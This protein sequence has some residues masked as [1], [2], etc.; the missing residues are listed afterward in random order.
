MNRRVDIDLFDFPT[1]DEVLPLFKE[2]PLY[3]YNFREEV[4][5]REDLSPIEQ[6]FDYQPML[7]S[8]VNLLN[9]KAFQVNLSYAYIK[10]YFKR[11]IP[12]KLDTLND[13]TNEQWTNKVHFEN[14]TDVFFQKAFT[15]LDLLGHLL[16]NYFDL[17][18]DPKRNG[19]DITFN[20]VLYMLPQKDKKLFH[21]LL[22]IKKSEEFK[23]ASSIRNDIIHSNPPYRAHIRNRSV[24]GVVFTKTHY[25]N[26]EELMQ[27]MNKLLLTMKHIFEVVKK[28]IE[29]QKRRLKKPAQKRSKFIHF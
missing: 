10:Y 5:Y 28:H 27:A 8:N 25:F 22:R 9:S 1:K 24:Q 6:V 18:A 15:T 14:N 4:F 17:N 3:N 29:D 21:K 16:F 2:S 12:D 19:T 20:G 7:V 23:T 13:L 11:G 26:S